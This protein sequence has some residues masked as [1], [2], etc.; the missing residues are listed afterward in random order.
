MA[1]LVK[2]GNSQGVRIPKALIQQA[3]LEGKELSFEIVSNGL[4]ISPS[5]HA[6]AGWKD[7]IAA[8]LASK[9]KEPVDKDWLD[10]P[11]DSDDALEW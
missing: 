4:L 7:E 8:I 11:L 9:G 10:I 6:R 2:I 5:K 3:S 1:N